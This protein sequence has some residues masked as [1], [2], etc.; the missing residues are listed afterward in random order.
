M[1]LFLLIIFEL[2]ILLVWLVDYTTKTPREKWNKKDAIIPIISVVLTII[3]TI[4]CFIH[5]L[6]GL[7]LVIIYLI[8]R[9]IIWLFK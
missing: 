5:P 1:F 3:I 7:L 4:F 2:S 9:F 6:I 8:I